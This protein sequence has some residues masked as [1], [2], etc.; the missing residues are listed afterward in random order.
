MSPDPPAARDK[1]STQTFSKSTIYFLSASYT[2][3]I[4]MPNPGSD[5]RITIPLLFVPSNSPLPLQPY[6]R[7]IY[8]HKRFAGPFA[9][10]ATH[11][12]GTTRIAAFRVAVS[13]IDNDFG[14]GGR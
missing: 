2:L 12:T 8:P 1:E 3:S 11:A 13:I 9:V 6:Q 7:I 10:T 14:Q 5:P 4:D